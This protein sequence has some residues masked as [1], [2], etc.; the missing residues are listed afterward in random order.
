VKNKIKWEKNSKNTISVDNHNIEVEFLEDELKFKLK[1]NISL[2]LPTHSGLKL[3]KNN[4]N[5]ISKT[6]P[7]MPP[8]APIIV[9]EYG[10][11]DF[12]SFYVKDNN[13]NN[14]YG[15]YDIKFID[16]KI[17]FSMK[18][19]DTS[20]DLF[21]ESA[22][23]LL[24]AVSSF[25]EEVLQSVKNNNV[26]NDKYKLID[27]KRIF[28][29]DLWL[30]DGTIYHNYSDIITFLKVLK[31]NNLIDKTLIFLAGF[32]APFD[33]MYPE[34]KAAYELGGEKK[35]KEAVDFARNNNCML[36][37]HINY[38]GVSVDNVKM[39]RK[40]EKFRLRYKN[41]EICEGW[42]GYPTNQIVYIN[43]A[44]KEFQEFIFSQIDAL[45]NKYE[46]EAIH[47][48]QLGYT[49]FN[50]E[51]GFVQ[52][53]KN[54]FKNFSKI[55]DFKIVSVEAFAFQLL[56][57]FNLAEL[58]GRP[59]TMLCNDKY[60]S[61]SV[62]EICKFLFK[63]YTKFYAH[64]SVPA[65]NSHAKYI[66]TNYKYVYETGVEKAFEDCWNFTKKMEGV[67]TLRVNLENIDLYKIKKVL[68]SMNL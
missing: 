29:F 65:M 54:Y 31:K 5:I 23:K 64:V 52:G 46:F 19:E 7:Y 27:L 60:E 6:S 37:P 44:N 66:F 21:F 41:G 47:L 4:F 17:S 13:G 9:F 20:Y 32:P 3:N 15:I 8:A 63:Y 61:S 34:Y 25:K 30:P 50:Y 56:G 55:F 24:D 18:F 51:N 59:W 11:D 2:H 22:S 36:M 43:P 33:T 53:V 39:L 42:T 45:V 38:W 16:S 10:K 14:N 1:G 48:D 26:K 49:D 57:L 68:N 58:L 35:L 62:S 28:I 12:V 67:P 40:F